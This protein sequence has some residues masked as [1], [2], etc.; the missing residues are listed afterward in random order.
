MLPSSSPR[1]LL[2][3]TGSIGS[4]YAYI[5]SRA[6]CNVTAVCRSNFS[7]I[8][9]QSF[10]PDVAADKVPEGPYDFV[11]V[12]S[13]SF[14]NFPLSNPAE[15]LTPAIRPGHL[16]QNGIEIEAPYRDEFP[17]SPVISRVAYSPVTQVSPAVSYTTK[18]SG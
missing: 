6:G 16:I 9:S 18:S 3:G 4:F 13:K 17:D 2:F 5:F 1:I 14:R 12:A 10:K 8:S 15:I 11:V 7:P